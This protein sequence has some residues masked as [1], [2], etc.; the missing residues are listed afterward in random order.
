MSAIAHSAVAVTRPTALSAA[1]AQ[2]A[3]AH[4]RGAPL[5][6]LAGCT[7]VLVE[8]NHGGLKHRSFIDLSGLKS[9]LGGHSW[10]PDG[11]LRIG[12]LCTYSALLADPR[13]HEAFPMLTQAA[14]LVGATQIQARGT[15]AGNVEN[16]S[17]AADAAP[18]LLALDAVVHLQS[19][20]SAR[21]VPLSQ[22]YTGYR[23]TARRP[24][25]LIVALEVPPAPAGEQFFRKVGTRAFQAITKVGISARLRWHEGAI[26]DARVVA[27]SMAATICRATHL[28]NALRGVRGVDGAT[29]Q[30]LRRA[31]DA[32][33]RPIDDVR[34]Q[35]DYRA[36]VFHRM[37][38]Q[39]VRETRA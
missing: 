12:A 22:Y 18:A 8:A 26:V 10:L 33:L 27:T 37:V 19:A 39:A 32:D 3:D 5:R 9:E 21:T 1:L 4:V 35:G 38:L 2:L 29:S 25:E 6:A 30:A 14:G 24:D 20:S 36:E 7:D 13:A 23:A 16:A 17:P 31:Q 34:S 15:F 28:E 11:T